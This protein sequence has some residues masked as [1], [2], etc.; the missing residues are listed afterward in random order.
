MVKVRFA[1][2]EVNDVFKCAEDIR[3]YIDDPRSDKRLLEICEMVYDQ[4]GDFCRAKR[5]AEHHMMDIYKGWVF[6]VIG[7]TR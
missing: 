1:A 6:T 2:H 3:D 7:I 4:D 5:N